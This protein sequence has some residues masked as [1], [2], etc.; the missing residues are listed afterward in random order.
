MTEAES[1]TILWNFAL[2]TDRKI[3]CNRPDF[4]VK[5]YK[6]KTCL[7]IDISVPTDNN[8]SVTEYNKITKYKNLKIE[9]EKMWHL[10]TTTTPV[11]MGAL[12]MI[13]KRTDKHINKIPGKSSRYEIQ[14]HFAELLISLGE[15]F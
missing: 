6:R 9:I 10:K 3:K 4:V 15:Y 7:L 11:I 1:T 5:D 8:M 14:L 12:G 2:Q 13:E